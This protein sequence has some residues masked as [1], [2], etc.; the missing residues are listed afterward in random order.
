MAHSHGDFYDVLAQ[1]A[2]RNPGGEAVLLG[3]DRHTYGEI[4]TKVDALASS[5]HTLGIGPGDRVALCLGNEIEWVIAFFALARLRAPA[6]LVSAS[7]LRHEITHAFTVTNPAGVITDTTKPDL[8]DE[9]GRPERAVLVGGDRRAGWLPFG[10]LLAGSGPLPDRGDPDPS[11]ELVLP[12]SSGTTGLPKAVRHSHGG[13]RVATEQWR[14]ALGITSTDRVQGITP[15]SHILG[16]V[17]IGATFA[18]GATMRLFRK[19]DVR[20]MVESF[21]QDRITIGITVAPIASA[22]ATFDGLERHRLDSVRYLNWSATPVNQEVARTVTARTGVGWLPAYGATEVPILAV[23]PY[24]RVPYGRLDS[25]GLPARDVEIEAV[26][27]MTEEFLPR[28]RSGELVARSPA[29]M[30]GYLP[31]ES[32]FLAGGWYRTGDIGHVEPEGWVVVTDRSK[33]LIKVSGYQVSPVEIETVLSTSPLV[34][35]CA[36]F[37]V[38]DATRGEIACAAVVPSTG[39][40]A[41]PAEVIAWLTPQLAPYKQLRDVYFVDEIP[42]TPSGKIKRRLLPALTH[43]DSGAL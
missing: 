40:T 15:L 30:L 6:V 4:R 1:A 41:S 17:N 33:D 39:S 7:W 26:D 22:L 42:R 12:F 11:D 8:V 13:L 27:P 10:D 23:N 3:A 29:A 21:E 9:V 31:E 14:E 16:V 20:A 18:G 34:G 19:F 28:G 5:L 36:V 35:D 2:Q 24:D 25:V 37:G 38:P 32:A 43:T